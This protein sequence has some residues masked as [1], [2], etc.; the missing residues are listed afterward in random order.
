MRD[1]CAL[2][3]RAWMSSSTLRARVRGVVQEGQ[4]RRVRA[5][6]HGVCGGEPE[7]GTVL[8]PR[9]KASGTPSKPRDSRLG[10]LAVAAMNHD[11]SSVLRK[12]AC[13]LKADAIGGA[14]VC[15][16]AR[17][18]DGQEPLARGGAM[19]N[20]LPAGCH[21]SV[22]GR[23]RPHAPVT[24][25]VMPDRS[26]M[27]FSSH[28]SDDHQFCTSNF[29]NSSRDAMMPAGCVVVCRVLWG[30]CVCGLCLGKAL[31]RCRRR[32]RPTSLV[33]RGQNLRRLL[34]APPPPSSLQS[35]R[36]AAHSQPCDC[37]PAR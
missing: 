13:A 27:L 30:A 14:C 1:S 22:Q 29:T 2:G 32:R 8:A 25:A 28:V 34:S 17:G 3:V 16:A 21:S 24:S 12:R 35:R 18:L 5:L 20:R 11:A 6:G 33:T 4:Q 23:H 26:G 36:A 31:R 37:T 10:L 9:W 15:R 7:D 19:R